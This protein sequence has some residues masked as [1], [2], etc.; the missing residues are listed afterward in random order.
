VYILKNTNNKGLNGKSIFLYGTVFISLVII[1][2]YLLYAKPD[3][4]KNSV[5]P[6]NTYIVENSQEEP[7]PSPK[8][9]PTAHL[10][11][12]LLK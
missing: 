4:N 1:G 9:E 7:T 2:Y 5:Q 8:V 6:T 3:E 12:Q 10:S 11:M